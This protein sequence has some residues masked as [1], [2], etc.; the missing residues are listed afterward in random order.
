MRMIVHLWNHNEVGKR[1]LEDVVGII[2]QQLRALGHYVVH[3]PGNDARAPVDGGQVLYVAKEL[4]YNLIVE[5][6]TDWS[7]AMLKGAYDN[8]ARF[9]CIATEEPTPAGFNHGL[10][11]EMVQRQA[12]FQEAA[13]YL[14]GI[15]H[16]VP[17][18][19]VTDWYAQYAPTSYLEL[20]YAPRL[21]RP[22]PRITPTYEFG[23]YGSMSPRRKALLTRLAR[24]TGAKNAVRVVMDFK[25]QEARDAAMREAKVI[26]QVRKF[27]QM[28]L[29]SSSRCNTALCIGRPVVAEPHE[30]SQGWEDVV[31]FTRTEEEFISVALLTRNRWREAHALQF[32]RFKRKFSPEKCVGVA[33]NAVVG[34]Q[35][36]AA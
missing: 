7:V 8:G 15:W 35:R 34:A 31:K 1:S 22:D 23:F 33:L 12:K 18:Q 2:G 24:A 29:V 26:V 11:R 4:G 14:D 17:G 28:G 5:G 16:L 32:E 30:L 13:P 10:D 36:V 19:A 25:T 9:I 3:D 27:D 6:F 21:V 20:G